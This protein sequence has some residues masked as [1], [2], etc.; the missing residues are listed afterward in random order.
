MPGFDR[1]GPNGG[2]PMTGR[3]LGNCSG[4][5]A[6]PFFG[7]GRG[8]N[9]RMGFGGSR[10]GR[11]YTVISDVPVFNDSRENDLLNEIESLKTKINSL[12]KKL[13]REG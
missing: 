6:R 2:G 8:M 7:R 11:G 4:A 3:G 9:Y 1:T 13:N 5:N 10:M 12:E